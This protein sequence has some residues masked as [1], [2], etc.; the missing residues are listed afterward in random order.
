MASLGFV[1]Y[2]VSAF[3]KMQKTFSIDAMHALADILGFMVLMNAVETMNITT[4]LGNSGVQ[5]NNSLSC[6][7]NCLVA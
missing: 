7:K 3:K 2:Y 1:M 6:L 5:I 4:Q